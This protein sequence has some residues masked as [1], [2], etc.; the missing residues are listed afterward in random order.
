M[1]TKFNWEAS[2]AE[3]ELVSEGKFADHELSPITSLFIDNLT[4]VT[5]LDSL[6]PQI[7][8]ADMKGKFKAWRKSTST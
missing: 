5:D 8:V 3:S 6:P 4:R 1:R 7:T 2:T